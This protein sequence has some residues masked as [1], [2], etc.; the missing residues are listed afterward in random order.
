ME[1]A[2]GAV[3]SSLGLRFLTVER[4]TELKTAIM[5]SVLALTEDNRNIITLETLAF[6]AD[7]KR[8]RRLLVEFL[9]SYSERKEE[10]LAET[11]YDMQSF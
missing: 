7:M 9:D 1:N 5:H 10:A 11:R 6:H 4:D 8:C 3:S 2:F